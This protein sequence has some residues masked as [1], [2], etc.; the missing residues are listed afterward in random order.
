MKSSEIIAACLCVLY[1]HGRRR[2]PSSNSLALVL[3]IPFRE[4][5]LN[6]G[7]G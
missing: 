5:L 1:R 6:W 7:A 4:A 2:P 3:N